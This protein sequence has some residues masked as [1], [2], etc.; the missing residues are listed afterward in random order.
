MLQPDCLIGH[1]SSLTSVAQSFLLNVSHFQGCQVKLEMTLQF[2]LSFI[3]WCS[4]LV[5]LVEVRND[6]IL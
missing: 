6:Y 3:I 5:L 1:F 2:V 4:L